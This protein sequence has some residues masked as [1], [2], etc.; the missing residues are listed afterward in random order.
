MHTD[1]KIAIILRHNTNGRIL[2]DRVVSK[3]MPPSYRKDIAIDLCNRTQF[4]PFECYITE[5]EQNSISEGLVGAFIDTYD[6][7]Q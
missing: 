1:S 2:G 6:I 4:K 5:H 7:A 3:S